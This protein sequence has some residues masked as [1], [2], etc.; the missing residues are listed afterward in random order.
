M[1]EQAVNQKLLRDRSTWPAHP[2]ASTSPQRSRPRDRWQRRNRRGRPR[3]GYRRAL[4]IGSGFSMLRVLRA[5]ERTGRPD[6]DCPL[7]TH[8]RSR[9]EGAT[10]GLGKRADR[11]GQSFNRARREAVAGAM[12]VEKRLLSAPLRQGRAASP[13]PHRANGRVRR[14][15]AGRVE[16][17]R[18]GTV[19]GEESAD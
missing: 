2:P 3:S 6:L 7:L 16:Q 4:Q 14:Q 1:G 5:S 9:S 12:P 10:P 8:P 17:A 19:T 11:Y 13:H 18:R 15:R